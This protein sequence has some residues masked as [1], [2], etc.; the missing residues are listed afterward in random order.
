MGLSLLKH[1]F[2]SSLLPAFL[3]GCLPTRG[4]KSAGQLGATDVKV[5]GILKDHTAS[6]YK[7]NIRVLRKD[8]SGLLIFKHTD[9]VTTRISF[10]TEVG[11]KMFEYEI[12]NH[13]PKLTYVFAPLNKQKI[14]K[15][16]EKDLQL[17]LLEDLSGH[18]A[19]IFKKDSSKIYKVETGPFRRYYFSDQKNKIEKV[20][21]RK[22]ICKTTFV[23][24][25]FGDSLRPQQ[26]LLKNKGLVAVKFNLQKINQKP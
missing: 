24:Y 20:V 7:T 14:L 18:D 11:M 4:Y 17:I 22:R 2:L 9:S 5:S 8:Y 12:K 25:M 15:L 26:I 16:L 21:E 10:V 3:T 23:T 13:Q 19:Q 6:I 1:L